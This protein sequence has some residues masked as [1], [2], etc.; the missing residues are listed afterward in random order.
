MSKILGR[1]FDKLAS[2]FDNTQGVKFGYNDT[3]GS[4]NIDIARMNGD[5]VSINNISSS[6]TPKITLLKDGIYDSSTNQDWGTIITDKTLKNFSVQATNYYGSN[7]SGQ[8]KTFTL[9]PGMYVLIVGGLNADNTHIG[10]WVLT[11]HSTTSGLKPISTTS[12]VT[13]SLSSL[14]LTV[15][16]NGNYTMVS[17]FK[18]GGT[19]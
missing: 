2:M 3:Y 7:T 12:R 17:L 4:F 5:A 1:I 18:V 15:K 13:V 8:T 19:S 11:A 16:L 6:G 9:T 10:L 14:T